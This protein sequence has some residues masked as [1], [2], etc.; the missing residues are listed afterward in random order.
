MEVPNEH[1]F[2]VLD[3]VELEKVQFN[4]NVANDNVLQDNKKETQYI[5]FAEDGV[6]RFTESLVSLVSP[7]SRFEL[8]PHLE[9][10]NRWVMVNK[11]KSKCLSDG[12]NIRGQN[13]FVEPERW[14]KNRKTSKWLYILIGGL[15][16]AAI[17][18]IIYVTKGK[19]ERTNK[20]ED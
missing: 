4:L 13:T 15:V 18:Y 16:V 10:S 8:S 11:K 14:K 6:T 20:L 12:L 5:L 17:V 7:N 19:S 2:S 1:S 3:T 9:C